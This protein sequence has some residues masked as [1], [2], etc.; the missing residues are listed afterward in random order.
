MVLKAFIPN[1]QFL[2]NITDVLKKIQLPQRN[3]RAVTTGNTI[4]RGNLFSP[5][6]RNNKKV[7]DVMTKMKKKN[8]S[9]LLNV[10]AKKMGFK[11]SDEFDN[12]I[13]EVD[14][15]NMTPHQNTQARKIYRYLKLNKNK[16]TILKW[17]V[18]GASATSL[19]V[20]LQNYQKKHSGCFRYHKDELNNPIRYKFRGNIHSCHNIGDDQEGIYEGDS[21]IKLLDGNKHPLYRT[22]KWDC[23]YDKFYKKTEA[24]DQILQLGCNGLCNLENFNLIASGHT[25]DKFTPLLNPQDV[26]Y[27]NYIFKCENISLLQA[28][29]QSTGDTVNEL[30]SGLFDSELGKQIL[31]IILQLFFIIIIIIIFYKTFKYLTKPPSIKN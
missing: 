25:M 9:H 15:Y 23:N 5:L 26:N 11:N 31:K 24:V 18:I 16:K 20:Y 2:D 12:F 6:T 22:L 13:K 30:F 27:D 10:E 14:P 1:F 21:Q 29:S 3:P 17:S 8:N 19:I 7:M 28:L 4:T